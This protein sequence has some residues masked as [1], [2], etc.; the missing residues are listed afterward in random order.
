MFKEASPYLYQATRQRLYF[1]Q[2][3]IL[4]PQTWSDKDTYGSPG[5][6]TFDTADVILAQQ[7][8]RFAQTHHIPSVPHAKHFEG[9]GKQAAHIHFSSEFLTFKYKELFHGNIGKNLYFS[10]SFILY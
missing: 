4:V 2:V 10:L 3:T 1:R 5:N 6:A 8:P 9:C 7:D